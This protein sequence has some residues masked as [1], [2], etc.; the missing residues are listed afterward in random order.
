MEQ[1]VRWLSIEKCFTETSR[2]P[3]FYPADTKINIYL[4]YDLAEFG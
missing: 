1:A 4:I 2:Y 3:A